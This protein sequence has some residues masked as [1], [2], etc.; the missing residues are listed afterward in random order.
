M[1]LFIKKETGGKL[2][3]KIIK[4]QDSTLYLYLYL[5][6]SR[7][8]QLDLLLLLMVMNEKRTVINKKKNAITP[9]KEE[10]Q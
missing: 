4:W 9:N 2:M 6:K 7:T 8:E 3:D 5:Y 1:P 10:K